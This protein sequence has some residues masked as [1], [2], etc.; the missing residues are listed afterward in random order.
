ME[1]NP[2]H[3]LPWERDALL[4]ALRRDL[5]SE[6]NLALRD[7]KWRIWHQRNVQL[8]LRVLEALNP[9]R[10]DIAK[11]ACITSLAEPASAM[12]S[13]TARMTSAEFR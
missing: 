3:L 4:E 10:R 2:S 13:Q 8:N 11:H 12:E 9:K 1:L 7:S 5:R 6:R